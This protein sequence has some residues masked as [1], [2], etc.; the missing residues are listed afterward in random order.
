M[1]NTPKHLV[2]TTLGAA[3]ATLRT[4]PAATTEIY[5]KIHVTNTDTVE[6]TFSIWA[7]S[8]TTDA[9][10]LVKDMALGAGDS[11][12]VGRGLILEAGELLS[13]QASVAAKLAVNASGVQVT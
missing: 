13:G 5:T 10:V 2:K 11:V 8:G 12:E 3:A 1:A 7:G 9:D 6:R 4:T